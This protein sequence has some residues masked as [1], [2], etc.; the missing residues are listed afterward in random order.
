MGIS[1]LSIGEYAYVS[2]SCSLKF[3]RL[4]LTNGHNIFGCKIFVS[5]S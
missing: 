5:D 2:V 3:T 4:V 1:Y